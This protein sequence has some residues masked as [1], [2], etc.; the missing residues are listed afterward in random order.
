[1]RIASLDDAA[2]LALAGNRELN[3]MRLKAANS[4]KA[5]KES[6]WWEDP[7]LDMDLMRIVNPSAHPFLGG[8]SLAFTIPLSG[9]PAREAAAADAYAEAEAAEIRAAERDL[10]VEA[11]RTFLKLSALRARAARLKA[12]ARDPRIVRA[13]AQV[14]RLRAAGE[15]SATE[16]AGLSRTIHAREHAALDTER[17]IAATEINL[18]RLLGLRPDTR[19]QI[20]YTLPAPPPRAPAAPDV[21]ALIRH[22]RVDA[23]RARLN[24]TEAALDAEIRR[25]YPELT[26]GPAAANEEGLDRLG[27]VAGLTLPL[28]NRNRRPIAEAEGAR[29]N[30]RRSA[31][32]IWRALVCDAAAARAALTTLLAHPPAPPSDRADADRLADAGELTPLDYLNVREEILAAHLAELDWQGA[33]HLA[34][35]ELERFN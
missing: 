7:E 11:R 19:L 16:R 8:A 35:A 27:L 3:A 21:R 6:G 26:L 5:A 28:W 31:V 12:Y 34:L 4:A 23:A 10:A 33:V 30:A 25:Q 29:D 32:D 20:T 24:G 22:P 9:V 18:L 1:V 15:I 14:D 13:L 17:E 2:G